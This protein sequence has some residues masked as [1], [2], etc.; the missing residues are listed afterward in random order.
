MRFTGGG[1]PPAE[2]RPGVGPYYGGVVI[3]DRANFTLRGLPGSVIGGVRN[4]G[5]YPDVDDPPEAQGA[6]DLAADQPA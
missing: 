5:R 6:V 1:A 2:D 4:D 3:K